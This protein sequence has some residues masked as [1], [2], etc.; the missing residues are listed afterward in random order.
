MSADDA[1]THAALRASEQRARDEAPT[2]PPATAFATHYAVS[3]LPADHPERD[4]WGVTV[5][6]RGRGRWAV[7]KRGHWCLSVD[8]EWSY[9]SIPSE[10]TDEWLAAHRF[11][12][13]T[14]LRL[15]KEQAPL[16]TVNG[17]TV[18]DVLRRSDEE[19]GR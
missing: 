16:V 6:Y 5:E 3:C 9:E 15:A 14:A 4:M 18:S 17:F 13:E 7:K 10:R 2:L 11:D 1:R 19:A 8:G 12:L